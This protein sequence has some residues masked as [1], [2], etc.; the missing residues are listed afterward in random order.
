MA[1]E[2]GEPAAPP[3]APF[4]WRS[5]DRRLIAAIAVGVYLLSGIYVVSADQQAVV[6][7]FGASR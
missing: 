3:R 2:L 4:S 7:R 6:S 1:V 5:L